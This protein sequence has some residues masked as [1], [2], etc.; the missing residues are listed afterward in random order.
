MSGAGGF[1]KPN[2]PPSYTPDKLF[3]LCVE[4]EITKAK[5]YDANRTPRKKP[6]KVLRMS[7][8]SSRK[9]H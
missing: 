1:C 4:L 7:L 5:T 8:V 6:P 3:Q 9:T 2:M